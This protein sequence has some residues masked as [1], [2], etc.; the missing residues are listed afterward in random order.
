[1]RNA[2]EVWINGNRIHASGQRA[3]M[4][5][6]EFLRTDQGLI[7]TKIVCSEGDCGACS[8]LVGRQSQTGDSLRY[9][10]VDACIVFMYQLDRAHVVTVE[11]LSGRPGGSH[12]DKPEACQVPLTAIQQA[13]VDGHGSQCG[14]C[15]PG[16]VVAMHGMCEESS[17]NGCG[18][19]NGASSGDALDE[20]DLRLGLSGNLC[21]CTGYVQIVRAGMSVDT[22]MVRRM[23]QLYPPRELIDGFD[24]LSP[25]PIEIQ[26][27]D[28]TVFVPGTIDQ[29]TELMTQHPGALLVAG[30][31]DVGVW[32]NHGKPDA[33][34]SVVITNIDDLKQI[35][36][37]ETSIDVGAGTTWTACLDAF[38]ESFPAMRD[39]LL[40]FGSPQIRNLGTIGGNLVNASPIAD[41]IPFLFA[42]DATITLAG[43][44]GR[45]QVSIDD[46]FHGYKQTD[47]KP[48][49]L[50]QSIECPKLSSGQQLRLYKVSRR[51]DMDISTFTAAIRITLDGETIAG[52]RIALGGVG[53]VVMRPA[54]A[55]L[56]MRGQPFAP[57][58]F[59][60]A[61]E[62]ARKEI[63]AIS[64]VRGS[65]D[66]R[67]QLTENIFMKCYHELANEMTEATS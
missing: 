51:R 15:T 5:L 40:R 59:R 19:Q 6:S 24:R 1:M 27:D 37:T 20:G 49:E 50:V 10:T 58:S 61:G 44:S 64:D 38:A 2:V 56:A 31:T 26:A 62:I 18:Q 17:A 48:G 55:E 67:G 8:V 46:F 4:T 39:I 53:P 29:A 63:A 21:R 3:M 43:A 36:E 32:Y 9:Q 45:R 30:A 14:F 12:R 34:V 65:D 16:F 23:N 57:E 47:R 52:V 35:K 22:S 28:R 54:K 25:D 66:Y 60:R 7:G 33:A 42:I 41:S 13:M 11:G